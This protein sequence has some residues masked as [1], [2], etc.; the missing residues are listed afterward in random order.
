MHCDVHHCLVLRRPPDAQILTAGP[1]ASQLA[2]H[3]FSLV[4]YT[5]ATCLQADAGSAYS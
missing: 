1:S 5:Q 2:E 4:Q 3:C